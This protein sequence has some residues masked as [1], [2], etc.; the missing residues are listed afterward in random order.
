MP[1]NGSRD[2]SRH[3]HAV[4]PEQD[5]DDVAEIVVVFV[6]E[7]KREG[8]VDDDGTTSRS[9]R[10]T[11]RVM[12]MNCILDDDEFILYMCKKTEKSKKIK[13]KSLRTKKSNNT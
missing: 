2:E 8:I 6:D 9:R 12:M 7:T 4:S 13:Y 1:E 11:S 10:N 3:S 5:A